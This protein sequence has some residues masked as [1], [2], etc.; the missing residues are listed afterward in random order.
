MINLDGRTLVVSSTAETGIVGSGTVLRFIQRERRIA[1]RYSGGRVVRGWLVGEWIG[2]AVTF[3][4]AQREEGAGIH[5][6]RSSCEVLRLT[7]DRLRIIEHFR[8]S[9]RVGAGT[10]AFDEV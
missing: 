8:W 2:D 7:R 5:A 4:Y 1:A 10:N 9:T 3:R 6:G